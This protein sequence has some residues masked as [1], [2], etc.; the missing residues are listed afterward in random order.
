MNYNCVKDALIRWVLGSDGEDGATCELLNAIPW[1][2]EIESVISWDD[3]CDEIN[4]S[5]GNRTDE[6]NK[7][8]DAAIILTNA[9]ELE[10][11]HNFITEKT[12]KVMT[13][14][15]GIIDRANSSL[16]VKKND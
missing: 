16:T 1:G 9:D 3:V 12:N 7:W 8:W 13:V 5:F 6:N 11:F 2:K 4:D 14:Y 10:R 15:Q